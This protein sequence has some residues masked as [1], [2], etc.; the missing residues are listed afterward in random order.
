M[1]DSED[2]TS[3]SVMGRYKIDRLRAGAIA[4]REAIKEVRDAE[5]R[6]ED[7]KK[8]LSHLR[9]RTLPDL[10]AEV[11]TDSIGLS[12]EG[13]SPGCD[14]ELKTRY[15]AVIP[16]E[17]PEPAFEWLEAEGH[18]DLIKSTFTVRF[19]RQAHAAAYSFRL[20][21]D[22]EG[23]SFEEK[24]EVHWATLTAF[25]REQIEQHGAVIPLETLGARIGREAVLKEREEQPKR[26]RK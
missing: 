6:L 25:V 21:L 13:N 16:K 10:F 1:S 4:M 9:E 17:N 11:G 18:G 2:L 14:L 22:R 5:T 19:D 23:V 3:N 7:A 12:A 24:M 26:S 20:L 15:H 8:R